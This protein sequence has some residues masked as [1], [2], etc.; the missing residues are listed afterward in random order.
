[1]NGTEHD[2]GRQKDVT[3]TGHFQ[4]VPKKEMPLCLSRRIADFQY[5]QK[6][7][8][9]VGK[10]MQFIHVLQVETDGQFAL[11]AGAREE[12]TDRVQNVD[13]CDED[14]SAGDYIVDDLNV[15]VTRVGQEEPAKIGRAT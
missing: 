6:G 9:L 1:M 5:K 12:R 15:I 4:V 8:L 11:V 3:S 2:D 14:V 10:Q 7:N 13:E